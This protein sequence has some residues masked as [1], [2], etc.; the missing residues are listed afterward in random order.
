MRWFSIGVLALLELSALPAQGLPDWVLQ[1][2][3]AK[4]HARS[5][6]ERLPNYSCFQT[7]ERFDKGPRDS[8]FR[9][10]DTLHLEVAFVGGK[11]LYAQAGGHFDAESPSDIVSTGAFG[12]GAF[13][14]TARNLFVLDASRPT[15][16]A[17]EYRAG[18]AEALRFDFA[19]SQMQGPLTLQSGAA[20]AVVGERGSFWVAPESLD[21][22]EIEDH[23]VD[24][25]PELL[26]LD[27][28]TN[29]LYAKVRIG[30]SDVILPKT[31][32]MLVVHYG[33]ELSRNVSEFS[34]CREYGSESTI[35]FG[36][37]PPPPPPPPKKK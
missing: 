16:W 5:N 28:Q 20:R 15:G 3:R 1:L 30:A 35:T 13:T 24:I 4:R 6:F 19:I 21:L 33:G 10:L 27:S 18:K 9:L 7:V 25:P 8:A 11:E 34:G 36:D 26:M 23:A 29:I 12:T 14:S 32:E 17:R 37:T 22:L 2:S 31:A